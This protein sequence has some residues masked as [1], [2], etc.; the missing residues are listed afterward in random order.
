MPEETQSGS[1]LSWS[2]T[3]KGSE[4][5]HSSWVWPSD[6]SPVIDPQLNKQLSPDAIKQVILASSILPPK[7]LTTVSD[8]PL[9]LHLQPAGFERL[10]ITRKAS[11]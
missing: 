9:I 4:L 6:W 10:V 2:L 3:F 7:T 11:A 8:S 5:V 1:H